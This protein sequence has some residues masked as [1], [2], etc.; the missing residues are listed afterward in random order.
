VKQN[1]AAEY[2]ALHQ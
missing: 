1:K 2:T